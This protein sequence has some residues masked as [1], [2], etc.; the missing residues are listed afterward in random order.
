M[1]PPRPTFGGRSVRRCGRCPRRQRAVV[2]LRFFDDLTEAQ[3]AEVL[4]CSVGTVKSQTSKALSRLR[5]CPQ[6]RGV[7]EEEEE[8]E[9]SRDPR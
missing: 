4:G 6:L 9:V 8:E 5:G 1:R 3:A 2:V 7:F